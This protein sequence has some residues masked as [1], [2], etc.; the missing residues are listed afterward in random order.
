VHPTCINKVLEAGRIHRDNLA[1]AVQG[2][3]TTQLPL[4]GPTTQQGTP[5]C[6]KLPEALQVMFDG[7]CEESHLY[8]LHAQ[9]LLFIGSSSVPGRCIASAS[10][11]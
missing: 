9:Q 10:H 11:P 7:V 8:C 3:V 6:S 4:R 2:N 1:G 5:I